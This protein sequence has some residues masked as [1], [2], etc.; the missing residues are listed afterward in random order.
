MR[1]IVPVL[2]FG[3]V[4]ALATTRAETP[5]NPARAAVEKAIPRI[6][7]GVQNY[8]DHRGCFSCHHQAMAM[9]SLTAA[10]KHGFTVDAKLLQGALDFSLKTF[11]NKD[12]IA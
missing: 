3:L 11:R 5:P 12:A 6:E 1:A 8:P 4:L 7:A 2:L 9:M 10:R